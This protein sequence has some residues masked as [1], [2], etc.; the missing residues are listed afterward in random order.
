MI[1]ISSLLILLDY[2]YLFVIIEHYNPFR[3]LFSKTLD[4]HRIVCIEQRSIVT[5][6]TL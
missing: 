1:L 2:V 6:R 4:V 5:Y 3:I